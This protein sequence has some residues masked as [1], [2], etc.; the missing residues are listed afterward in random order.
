M[1]PI[2]IPQSR[3]K[4]LGQIASA[5]LFAAFVVF[6]QTGGFHHDTA[7]LATAAVVLLAVLAA[8]SPAIFALVRPRV[9]RLDDAGFSLSGGIGVKPVKLTWDQTGAFVVTARGRNTPVI[10][11][12]LILGHNPTEERPFDA[13]T[14]GPQ[15]TL[16]TGWSQSPQATVDLL[17]RYRAHANGSA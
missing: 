16:P 17:N 12:T 15:Q 4:S 3:L 9:L 5:A 13:R 8:A 2:D 11:Y 14:R 1:P 6:N 10:N 7:S